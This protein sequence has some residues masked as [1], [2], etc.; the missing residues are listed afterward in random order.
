MPIQGQSERGSRGLTIQGQS[1]RGS[2][3]CLF[4]D[5]VG[6]RVEIGLYTDRV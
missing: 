6:E 2:R 3:E 4:R 5:R 1:E